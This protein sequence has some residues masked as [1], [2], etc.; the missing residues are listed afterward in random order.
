RIFQAVVSWVEHDGT[1]YV[2]PKSFEIPLNK[3]MMDIQSS[4]FNCLGLLETYHWK[5][6]EACIVRGSDT[7]WYR[8]KVT[9]VGGS[10]V[11]VQY[12]DWGFRELIPQCHLYPTTL[13]TGVP[14]FCIHCQLY[15]IVPVGKV[16]QQDAVSCLQELLINEE[17]EIHIQKLPRNPWGK[18]SIRLYF[19]GMSL[20]SFMVYQKYCVAE[21]S[22]V[23]A[24]LELLEGDAPVLPSYVLPSLPVPGDPFPVTV[25]HL[26]TPREVYIC[27]SPKNLMQG[28]AAE[29]DSSCQLEG[30]DEAL[31]WCNKIVGYLPPL[32]YFHAEMPCLVEYQDGLWHR[33]KL[34]SVHQ[35]NP[36]KILVQFVDYGTYF[37]VPETRVRP[38]PC[39]LLKYP[40]RA[41]RALLAGIKP[42]PYDENM[43]RIPYSPEWSMEALWA[44]VEC[45]EGKELSASILALS[46]EVTIS[47]CE[48]DKTLVHQ[49]LIEKGLAV[50][51]E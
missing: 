21:G 24:E 36:V 46:P 26:V 33:G 30:L 7:M 6:G 40:I 32:T 50:L 9:G 16:W 42:A 8:G 41:V 2:I 28:S 19:G 48:A 38:M 22:E 10:A 3:L 43:E 18:V 39:C 45:V 15:G 35:I 51:D 20:S 27:F 23:L 49:K 13:Y 1:I 14:P 47:L 5:K 34:L 12:I 29:T 4:F 25:T 17:V 11:Q 44:M 37:V 31:R